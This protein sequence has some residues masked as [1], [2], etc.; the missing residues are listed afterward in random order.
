MTHHLDWSRPA[1]YML[2][3]GGPQLSQLPIIRPPEPIPPILLLQ[4][5]TLRVPEGYPTLVDHPHFPGLSLVP[6]G[7]P[8]VQQVT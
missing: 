3:I 6:G 1:R 4:Y 2:T 8:P 5:P 7:Y